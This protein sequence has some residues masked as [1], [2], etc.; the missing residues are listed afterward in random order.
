[1]PAG[2]AAF[3]CIFSLLA[4]HVAFSVKNATPSIWGLIA[5]II[6]PIIVFIAIGVFVLF[7]NTNKAYEDMGY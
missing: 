3:F 5:S 7:L 2:M 6:T 4:Y 1:M